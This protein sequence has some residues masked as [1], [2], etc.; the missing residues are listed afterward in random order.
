VGQ[1]SDLFCG[2]VRDTLAPAA[3]N[4]FFRTRR[5]AVLEE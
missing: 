5:T 1:I 4:V 2:L 3:E